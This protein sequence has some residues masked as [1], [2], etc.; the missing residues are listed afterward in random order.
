MGYEDSAVFD[1][2]LI[3]GRLEQRSTLCTVRPGRG[4][5]RVWLAKR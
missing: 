4:R 5:V 2:V 1:G 3:G